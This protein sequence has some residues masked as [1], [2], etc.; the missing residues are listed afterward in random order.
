[1]GTKGMGLEQGDCHR[2]GDRGD[3]GG[4]RA[5]G[6]LPSCGSKASRTRCCG[7]VQRGQL[8]SAV[9]SCPEVCNC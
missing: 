8:A 6:E 2:P 3:G 5:G 4:L 1:M 7:Q 9:L